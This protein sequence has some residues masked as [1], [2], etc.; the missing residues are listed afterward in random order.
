M[1][2]QTVPEAALPCHSE[3]GQHPR[4][5]YSVPESIVCPVAPCLFCG[6]CLYASEETGRFETTV[7]FS[8]IENHIHYREPYPP[9]LCETVAS[10]LIRN[11]YLS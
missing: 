9:E 8:P 2:W 11:R 5:V 7:D 6:G 4:N 10:R 1:P 3:L